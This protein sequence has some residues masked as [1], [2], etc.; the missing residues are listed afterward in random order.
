[1][2][3]AAPLLL[4]SL[5]LLLRLMLLA[6]A[7]LL[8]VVLLLMLLLAEGG[9]ITGE[10]PAPPPALP[11][12]L[13]DEKDRCRSSPAALRDDTGCCNS[14]TERNGRTRNAGR[15][16]VHVFLFIHWPDHEESDQD[17]K[18]IG[19]AKMKTCLVGR[20]CD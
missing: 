10:S 15:A 13:S 1:M 7:V 16:S 5:L 14:Q 9:R 17:E 2:Q 8:L 6:L 4:S 19:K 12:L 11:L 18:T 20:P 3:L